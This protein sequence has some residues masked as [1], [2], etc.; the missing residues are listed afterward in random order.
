MVEMADDHFEI[1]ISRARDHLGWEPKHSLY[2]TLP[3][4]V[5]A[6]R[7][8]PLKWYSEHDLTAPAWLEEARQQKIG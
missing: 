3:R 6:L 5:E 1:D 4:M 2:E 7:A 8:D